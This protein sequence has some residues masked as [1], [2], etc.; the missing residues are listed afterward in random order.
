[1]AHIDAAAT[2]IGSV[3]DTAQ[4]CSFHSYAEWMFDESQTVPVVIP[5][6]LLCSC[7]VV[8]CHRAFVAGQV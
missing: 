3:C 4:L 8:T 2:H 5:N 7:D 1:M 6:F